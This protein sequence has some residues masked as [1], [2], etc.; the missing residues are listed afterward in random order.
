M[1][2]PALTRTSPTNWYDGV[3][4]EWKAVSWAQRVETEGKKQT[5]SWQWGNIQIL[6]QAQGYWGYMKSMIHR[7]G[8]LFTAGTDL[9]TGWTPESRENCLH[10]FI[11]HQMWNPP[12]SG[13][14]WQD[15]GCHWL[16][17]SSGQDFQ[18]SEC[19]SEHRSRP[20]GHSG[21]WITPVQCLL[22]LSTCVLKA[23]K[24][25]RPFFFL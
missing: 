10:W 16:D 12:L 2:G 24:R 4:S 20:E 22:L 23:R 21:R 13:S 8:H 3:S 15:Q 14:S 9:S 7:E 5:G 25:W 18:P 11:W 6:T 1:H 17:E 19:S